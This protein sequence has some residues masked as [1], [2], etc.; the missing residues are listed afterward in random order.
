MMVR[1]TDRQR[2]FYGFFPD[3]RQPGIVRCHAGVLSPVD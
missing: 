2:R 1:I 3:L